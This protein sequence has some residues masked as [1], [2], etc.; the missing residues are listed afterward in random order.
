MKHKIAVDQW[1][2]NVTLFIIVI[3]T[4][5]PFW[6]I[7][8]YSISDPL[9]AMDGG[10]FLVPKG[11]SMV[12]VQ[13]ILRSTG[14]FTAYGNTIFVT[15]VGTAIN[16]VLTAS[17][18]YPLSVKRFKGR[19]II[20]L[21]IFFTMLFQGGMIPSYILVKNLR[22]IDSRWALI[23]PGAINA[24]Y[25]F[26][27]KNYFQNLPQSLEESANIDGAT[28]VRILFTIILPISK[29]VIAAI[30]LFYGVFHWNSYIDSV[31]YINSQSKQVLQVF[32][33]ATLSS[34]AMQQLGGV[35]NFESMA[36]LTEETMKMV[37]VTM[38]VLPMIIVYPFIQKY[39][40]KGIMIGSIKG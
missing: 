8:M 12:G 21:M 7:M 28:P 6:H 39:Y 15:L 34:G 22:L 9:E 16:I 19:N 23:I 24:W 38:S 37:T 27:M 18:A 33:R 13:S 25:M 3:F 29:P 40:V 32:L 10:L 17:I 2:V 35:E 30:S 31:L 1:I 36:I 14:I 20:S 5:Y 11:F 4:L 26:I